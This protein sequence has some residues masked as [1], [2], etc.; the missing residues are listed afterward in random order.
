MKN[1]IKIVAIILL[2]AASPAAQDRKKSLTM[3]DIGPTA[4]RPAASRNSTVAEEERVWRQRVNDKEF[5]I[6]DLQLRSGFDERNLDLKLD[7]KKR[8]GELAS[9]KAE[10]RK[11]RFKYERSPEID[12]RERFVKVRLEMIREEKLHPPK[13]ARQQEER[14]YVEARKPRSKQQRLNAPLIDTKVVQRQ[15][16]KLERLAIQLD[17]LVEE[18]RRAGIKPW[19]FRD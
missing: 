3:Y 19:I 12:F 2:S 15:N 10:G 14:V 18:G 4:E 16:S 7:L 9:L 11:K 6:L 13:P 8:E 1:F 17:E 5:A